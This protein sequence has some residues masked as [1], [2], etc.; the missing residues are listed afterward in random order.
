MIKKSNKLV[1]I[2]NKLTTN[3]QNEKNTIHKCISK[4]IAC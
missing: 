2:Y 3:K 4:L 1:I